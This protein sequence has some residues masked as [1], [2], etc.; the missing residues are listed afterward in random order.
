[1]LELRDIVYF[2]SLILFFLFASA[3]IIDLR[4]AG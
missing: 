1:M 2:A 4:K 3:V